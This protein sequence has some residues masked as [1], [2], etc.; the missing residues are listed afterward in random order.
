MPLWLR[1][2]PRGKL[3][4]IIVTR[5]RFTLL[6][7]GGNCLKL[8]LSSTFLD[9]GE[10]RQ[11]LD[12]LRKK[13]MLTLAMEDFLASPS[14]PLET[15]LENLRNSDVMVLVI[16]ANTERDRTTCYQLSQAY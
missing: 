14:R 13:R 2:T 9:L 3:R 12:A 4:S 10:E 15:A 1:Q 7:D 8:F 11:V 5:V 16:E 6:S